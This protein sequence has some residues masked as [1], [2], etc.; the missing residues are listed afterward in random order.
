MVEPVCEGECCGGDEDGN[1]QT[2]QAAMET[3]DV[4]ATL[5]QVP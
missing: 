3:F 2:L 1:R 4:E 5:M